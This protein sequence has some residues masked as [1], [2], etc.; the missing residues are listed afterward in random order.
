M[1]KILT[2][3]S[4]L[5][6]I[7]ALTLILVKDKSA[8]KIGYVKNGEL[9]NG[10]KGMKE[11]KEIFDEKKTKWDMQLKSMESNYTSEVQKF[12][13]D[14]AT[15]SVSEIIER[16]VKIKSLEQEVYQFVNKMNQSNT[17]EDKKLTEGILNQINSFVSD[18]GKKNEYKIIFGT[19]SSGNLMYAED[20]MDITEE[21]LNVMNQNYTGE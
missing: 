21:I 13:E 16:K 5:V 2:I 10:F 12:Y 7:T 1:T 14:S 15:L 8:D 9:I 19:T 3:L 18:Y 4:L 17:E 6:S 11:A 20:N